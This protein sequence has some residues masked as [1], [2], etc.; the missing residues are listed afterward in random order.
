MAE[1]FYGVPEDLKA[2]CRARLPEPLRAVLARF[3]QA[4]EERA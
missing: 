4:V 1:G 3:E 2:E